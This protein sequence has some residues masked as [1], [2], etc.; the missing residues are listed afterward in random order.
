MGK[1]RSIRDAMTAIA[2][3]LGFDVSDLVPVMVSAGAPA[4]NVDLVWA[5][6]AGALTAAQSA[7]LLRSIGD[8]EGGLRLKQVLRQ[9]VKG[10]RLAAGLFR[11]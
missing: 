8:A 7:Q 2:D 6:L 1:A 10:G 11:G 5:R 3:D 4:Y 9:A